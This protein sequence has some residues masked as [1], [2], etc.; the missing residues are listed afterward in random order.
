[1]LYLSSLGHCL[2]SLRRS[3]SI[4][5]TGARTEKLPDIIQPFIQLNSIRGAEIMNDQLPPVTPITEEPKKNNTVLYVVIG[6]VVLCCC[7]SVVIGGW[8][9]WNNGDRLLQGASL[10]L[11]ML[12]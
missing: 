8:W 9:L 11:P 5:F 1:L 12:G 4:G 10:L 6:V 2:L 3:S 7:C